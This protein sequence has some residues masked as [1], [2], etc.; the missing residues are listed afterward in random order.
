MA[1]GVIE[2][3]VGT[4]PS[5]VDLAATVWKHTGETEKNLG[6]GAGRRAA[7][8]ARAMCYSAAAPTSTPP[9]TDTLGIGTCAFVNKLTAA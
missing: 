7:S 5:R 2:A 6:P 8:S 3:S 9:T 1:A 4:G